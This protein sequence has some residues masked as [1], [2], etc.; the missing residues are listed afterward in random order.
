MNIQINVNTMNIKIKFNI[1]NPFRNLYLKI[2]TYINSKVFKFL[3]KGKFNTYIERRALF[4]INQDA[5]NLL[6][7]NTST[8]L[9][10]YV[11][12][13]YIDDNP[14]NY[15]KI[16]SYAFLI[17]GLS[18]EKTIEILK[19]LNY[20]ILYNGT[21]HINITFNKLNFKYYIKNYYL[22]FLINKKLSQ[23]ENKIN[24]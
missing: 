16:N 3:Y 20:N 15:I 23:M 7:S 9:I 17:G 24:Y 11:R 5:Y 19:R 18:K 2:K 14:F 10:H 4:Y 6:F 12:S 8:S 22:D 13:K 21:D 1:I